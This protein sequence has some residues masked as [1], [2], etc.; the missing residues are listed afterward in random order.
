M[1]SGS[2]SP[3]GALTLVTVCGAARLEG[4]RGDAVAVIDLEEH[5]RRVNLGVGAVTTLYLLDALLRLPL[6]G[7]VPRQDLLPR[8]QERLSEVAAGLVEE[9]V[10]GL[11]RCVRPVAEVVGVRV[12]RGR[13]SARL[14]QAATFARCVPTEI[15]V[16]R[17]PS[18]EEMLEADYL[19]VGVTGNQTLAGRRFVRPRIPR[20]S[21]EAVDWLFSE[22]VYG[23][24]LTAED[25]RR[26]TQ[27]AGRR[28]S[29]PSDVT[30]GRTR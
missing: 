19:G 9:S 27:E 3:T 17:P 11:V 4:A 26:A 28:R 6:G 21:F 20:A 15:V 18:T 23:G 8:D 29:R 13:W 22:H 12:T 2:L 14:R 25:A 30:L 7:P 24:W 1:S 16:S 5:R 10:Q